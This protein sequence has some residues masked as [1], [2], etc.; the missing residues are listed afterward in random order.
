MGASFNDE[1]GEKT[2]K[3]EVLL[4]R[5]WTCEPLFS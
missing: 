3:G 4:L 1:R 5:A 2:I